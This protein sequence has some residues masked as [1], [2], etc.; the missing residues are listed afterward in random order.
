MAHTTRFALHIN[1]W[2]LRQ[3]CYRTPQG[4]VRTLNYEPI[5]PSPGAVLSP[6][7]IPAN[8]KASCVPRKRVPLWQRVTYSGTSEGHGKWWWKSGSV[9]RLSQW[10]RQPKENLWRRQVLRFVK[11]IATLLQHGNI[12]FETQSFHHI[13]GPHTLIYN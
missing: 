7:P 8:R 10:R 6:Q 9:H 13:R 3:C 4:M 12:L 11:T 5:I 1:K 2:C